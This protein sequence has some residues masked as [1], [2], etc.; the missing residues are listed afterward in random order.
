MRQK[1]KKVDEERAEEG[2][3]RNIS[4]L[5]LAC[6]C[7]NKA[8]RFLYFFF[9]LSRLFSVTISTYFLSDSQARRKTFA[10]SSGFI[11][12]FHL[13]NRNPSKKR[14]AKTFCPIERVPT[15]QSDLLGAARS[16]SVLLVRRACKGLA[17][18]F[19][20]SGGKATLRSVKGLRKDPALNS[21]AA[22]RLAVISCTSSS[23]I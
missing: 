9:R 23:S 10:N 13:E 18:T 8:F 2:V 4:V 14:E 12:H 17:P 11:S 7:I 1:K 20:E 16:A 21:S 5:R 19:L 6:L 22:A 3:K 15:A